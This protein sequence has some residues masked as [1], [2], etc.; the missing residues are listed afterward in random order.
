MAPGTICYAQC[1]MLYTDM[2][3]DRKIRIF[4]YSWKVA[5]NLYNFCRSADVDSV[6]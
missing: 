5:D 4:N 1:A 3:G 6:A 2:L